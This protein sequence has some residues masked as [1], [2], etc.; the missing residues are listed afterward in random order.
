MAVTNWPQLTLR[1]QDM[2]PNAL[3]M[4]SAKPRV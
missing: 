1:S 3:S 2:P 4:M